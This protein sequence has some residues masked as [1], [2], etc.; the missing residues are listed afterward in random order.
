M[1]V[2]IR[3]GMMED[4]PSPYANIPYDVVECPEHIAL[5]LEA[6]KRSMVLLKNDN[7]FLP[8]KQEQIHTIAVIG[9]NANSRAAL[10]GNYEGTSSRYITPLYKD[11]VEFLGE[12]KDRFKE[13][14]IAAER[15]DVIVM[16]LGLDA[17]IEGEEGDAGNE[18]ASGDKLGLKLPG[19]QQELL[20]AVA[21]VGKPI[22]LTVLAGTDTGNNGLLVPGSERWKSNRRGIVRRILSVRKTAC[23]LL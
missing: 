2:R 22:V 4:Y 1:D 11:Q 5:S 6:S 3:L 15:A 9:P 21:A 19:L 10:V 7:H 17:G 14:L 18:Y 8:L 12:P 23:Y 20:E 16:C 13:A